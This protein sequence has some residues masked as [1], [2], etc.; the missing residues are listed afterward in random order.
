MDTLP[1]ELVTQI[2]IDTFELFITLLRVPTIGNRLCEQYPQ[3]LAKE[4]FICI[5]VITS[6]GSIHSYLNSMKHSFNDQ[7]A[8]DCA[9]SGDKYWYAN[10]ERHRENDQPAS[11]CTNGYKSWYL[12]GK[13]HRRNDLPAVEWVNGDKHWYLYGQRHRE[14]DKPAIEYAN[15]RKEWFIHGKFIK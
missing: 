15:G 11:E 2:A 8:M 1:V 13:R 4:K 3:L 9:T 14:N 7:P 10:G 5:N 12:Y 6:Y